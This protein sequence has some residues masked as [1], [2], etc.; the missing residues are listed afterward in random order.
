M[1][2]PD[3][4]W[5][6]DELYASI[7]P[8]GHCPVQ[9]EGKLPD[10]EYYYFRARGHVTFDIAETKEALFDDIVIFH[11][12]IGSDTYIKDFAVSQAYPG[13]MEHDDAKELI[14]K[15]VQEYVAEKT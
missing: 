4:A 11:R 13:W 15:W 3:A 2:K 7:E 10:G 8:Y 9:A 12:E 1:R 6:E 5:Q 14:Y